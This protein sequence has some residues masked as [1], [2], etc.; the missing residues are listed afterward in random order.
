MN[1]GI[2]LHDTLP[3][4]LRQRLIYAKEQ[5]FLR[6]SRNQLYRSMDALFCR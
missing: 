4:S 2:R 6:S 5:G 1:I 3:G